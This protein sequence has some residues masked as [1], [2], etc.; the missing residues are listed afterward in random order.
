MS[1]DSI[2]RKNAARLVFVQAIYGEHFGVPIKSA[3]RWVERYNEDLLTDEANPENESDERSEEVFQLKTDTTPDM[4][5]LRKLLRGWLEEKGA[6]EH[7]LTELLS[8]DEKRGYHRLSPLI[9][10]CIAAGS[11]ELLHLNT[12]KPV[13]LKEYMDISGGFF[14]NPELGFIN[15]VLQEVANSEK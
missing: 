4:K 1:E 6:V 7:F 11:F 13:V 15:G 2:I 8:A 14:D 3:E 10:S 9:Q 5:F 12:K